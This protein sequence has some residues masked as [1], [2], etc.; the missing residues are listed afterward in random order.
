[1]QP[2][3]YHFVST[4]KIQERL[5]ISAKALAEY[6]NRGLLIAGVHFSV[7]PGGHK[8]YNVELLTDW[9]ANQQDPTS[10]QR[11]IDYYL[12]SLPCNQARKRAN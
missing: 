8:R 12:K 2:M 1:M 11:A 5:G 7:L 3:E 4:S 6:I 10:H 9:L